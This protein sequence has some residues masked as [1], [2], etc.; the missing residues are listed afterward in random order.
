M[1]IIKEAD[2]DD[3]VAQCPF[4][5]DFYVCMY[6]RKITNAT[7]TTNNNNNGDD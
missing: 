4:S 2:A 7:T 1:M 6:L 5:V 3:W